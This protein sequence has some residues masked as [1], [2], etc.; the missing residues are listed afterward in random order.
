VVILENI[1]SMLPIAEPGQDSF[2]KVAAQLSS[3]MMVEGS[4]C[5][6][7]HVCLVG[8]HGDHI[9]HLSVGV[10]ASQHTW[11]HEGV[12]VKV[13]WCLYKTFHWVCQWQTQVQL[14]EICTPARMY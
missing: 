3:Y 14:W 11:E 9:L 8:I 6:D 7:G 13:G 1:A 10:Q 2:T 5:H 4:I 12:P